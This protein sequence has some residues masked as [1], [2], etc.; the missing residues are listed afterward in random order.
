MKTKRKP[1]STDQSRRR[2]FLNW[3][4]DFDYLDT[5]SPEDLK[6]IQKFSDEFY[7]NGTR[8]PLQDRDQLRERWR[9]YQANR[10]DLATRRGVDPHTAELAGMEG[11]ARGFGGL[12]DR[13]GGEDT[14]LEGVTARLAASEDPL[15]VLDGLLGEPEP[16]PVGRKPQKRSKL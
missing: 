6:W 12:Q 5:L 10:R 13:A 11:A 16:E 2:P 4:V 3:Q 9:A 14:L 8:A 1:K 15:E 7:S